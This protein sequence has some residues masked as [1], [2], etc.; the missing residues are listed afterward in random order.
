MK[1]F[2]FWWAWQYEKIENWLEKME[3][4]GKKLKKMSCIGT[5]FYFEDS[6]PQKARYCVDYQTKLT[7]EYIKLATED[8][9]DIYQMVAGW[10]VL[11]KGYAQERP[12]FYCEYDSII[13]RNNKLS[14]VMTLIAIPTIAIGN[15]LFFVFR[16]SLALK[17]LG[18]AYLIVYI[19]I[20]L[21][22][23]FILINIYA[24]TRVLIK[25]KNINN[26]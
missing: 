8:G 20:T 7:P 9:W 3:M 1:I 4:K 16:N 26:R 6:L 10:I 24:T 23:M 19:I 22:Y 18:F 21:F 11:R 15:I 2:K 17:P 14:Q 13:A 12:D 5:V 25:K